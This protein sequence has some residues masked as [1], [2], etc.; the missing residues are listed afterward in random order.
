MHYQVYNV[1][2]S[3]ATEASAAAPVYFNPKTIDDMVLI[4]GGLLA[5]DP[6]LVALMH[7]KYNL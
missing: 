1:S 6:S 7:A 5:N 4:D 3:D 2:L